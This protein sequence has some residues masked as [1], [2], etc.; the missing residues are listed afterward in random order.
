MGR[1]LPVA[2]VL[3]LL[4]VPL[5][6]LAAFVDVT[7]SSGIA[8]SGGES[9]N[10][11]VSW[12]DLNTDGYPDLLFGGGEAPNYTNLAIYYADPRGPTSYLDVSATL[13]GDLGSREGIWRSAV[14]GD[15]NGD[16]VPDVVRSGRDSTGA[17]RVDVYFNSGA[18]DYSFGDPDFTA[19]GT[20]FS[21][22]DSVALLDYDRD[23]WLDVLVVASGVQI[24]RNPAD[25]SADFEIV[26]PGVTGLPTSGTGNTLTISDVNGDALPDVIARSGLYLNDG[27]GTFT[28]SA[29]TLDSGSIFCDFDGDGDLDAFAIDGSSDDRVY[30]Q[31]EDGSFVA[32][33]ALILSGQLKAASCGDADADGDADLFVSRETQGRQLYRNETDTELAFVLDA[34]AFPGG[35]EVGAALFTDYDLDGDEDLYVLSGNP[36]LWENDADPDDYI[37]V[38]VL[39][40]VRACSETEPRLRD[41]LGGRLILGDGAGNAL[42]PVHEI[43]SGMGEGSQVSQRTTF[44][45]PNGP[46]TVYELVVRLAE[47]MEPEMIV[48]VDPSEGHL[49]TVTHDRDLDGDG[50]LNTTELSDGLAIS[51]DP[52]GD[53][54]PNWLDEDSD[55]DGI[56]DAVEAGDSD[57]CTPPADTDGDGIPDYLDD[58]VSSQL[59]AEGGGCTCRLSSP[60][61]SRFGSG[62][63]LLLASA[64][65][66]LWIRRRMK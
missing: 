57:D 41:A 31:L 61:P 43:S 35:G 44:V 21:S 10:A 6:A 28:E 20:D 17:G 50:I 37:I 22:P 49:M 8:G 36:E 5:P 34:Q 30:E 11:G 48:P 52:D 4:L 65:G 18:S 26:G 39:E 66:A 47:P 24:L 45:L 2:W 59:F 56:S 9:E 27:D 62:L 12:A 38:Q 54:V 58:A 33:G 19:D 1:T 32:S 16:G 23:G 25:G 3:A 51:T 7:G 42:S 29:G 60:I 46:E 64:G 55:G 14:A 13:G 40:D 63:W 53:G 15:L